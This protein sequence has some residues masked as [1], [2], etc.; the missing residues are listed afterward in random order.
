MI[1]GVGRWSNEI[2]KE[3][4]GGGMKRGGRGCFVLT[5]RSED[6]LLK[7]LDNLADVYPLKL[8]DERSP[9]PSENKFSGY[10]HWVACSSS[11]T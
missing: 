8:T 9:S 6:S 5:N 3:S 1:G 4:V 11:V 2:R 10:L 7:M